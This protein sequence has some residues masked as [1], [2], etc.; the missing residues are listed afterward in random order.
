MTAERPTLFAAV[1]LVLAQII[2]AQGILGTNLIVNGNAETGSAGTPTSPVTT[3]PG[4]TTTG[5]PTLLPYGL[6]GFM[7]VT[8]PAPP[9]HGFQYFGCTSNAEPARRG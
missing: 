1:L 2:H 8:D 5:K 9:D 4:W 7:L 6:T 3:I